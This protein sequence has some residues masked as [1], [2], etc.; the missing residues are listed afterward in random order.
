MRLP[1]ASRTKVM[2]RR[3]K[4]CHLATIAS[5][6]RDADTFAARVKARARLGLSRGRP[7]LVGEMLQYDKPLVTVTRCSVGT[8]RWVK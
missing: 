2:T 8:L 4:C 3:S 1:A 5:E 6:W 7:A